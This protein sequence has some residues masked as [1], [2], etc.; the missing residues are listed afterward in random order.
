MK[1]EF[2]QCVLVPWIMCEC[3]EKRMAGSHPSAFQ[4]SP[5]ALAVLETQEQEILGASSETKA[6]DP[7]SVWPSCV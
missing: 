5:L 1:F 4:E 3:E 7:W 6:L 2:C